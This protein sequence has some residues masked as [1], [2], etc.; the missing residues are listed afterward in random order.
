[1]EDLVRFHEPVDSESALFIA[2]KSKCNLIIEPNMKPYSPYIPSKLCDLVSVDQ[3]IIAITPEQSFISDLSRDM[4]NIITV[5]HDI[6]NIERAVIKIFTD[7]N[8]VRSKEI[9]F[10]ER[11]YTEENYKR[12]LSS[13]FI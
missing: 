8:F 7:N 13:I 9:H 3:Y 6:D 1:M 12:I 10:K 11:F 4:K 2:S 5:N